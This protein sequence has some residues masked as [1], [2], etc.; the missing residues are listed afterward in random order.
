MS[1]TSDSGENNYSHNCIS[2]QK[3]FSTYDSIKHH[4]NDMVCDIFSEQFRDAV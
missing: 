3:L 1:I 4:N 2:E